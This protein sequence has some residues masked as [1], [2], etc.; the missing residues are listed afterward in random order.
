MWSR[1]RNL[2][3]TGPL[4]SHVLVPDKIM[5]SHKRDKKNGNQEPLKGETKTWITNLSVHNEEMVQDILLL[6]KKNTSTVTVRIYRY[7]KMSRSQSQKS[8]VRKLKQA[9][10][11]SFCTRSAEEAT[12][13]RPGSATPNSRLHYSLTYRYLSKQRIQE[14][15]MKKPKIR[16]LKV[17]NKKQNQI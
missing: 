2:D 7:Q 6:H 1:I 3:G 11:M 4:L 9:R 16:R 14:V 8:P 12:C 10:R 13:Q 17:K 15:K 5:L